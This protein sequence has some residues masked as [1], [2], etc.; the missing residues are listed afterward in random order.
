MNSSTAQYL[1]PEPETTLMSDVFSF[2]S[3]VIPYCLELKD[4]EER[5]TWWYSTSLSLGSWVSRVSF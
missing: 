3:N 5:E 1:I 2:S 4:V